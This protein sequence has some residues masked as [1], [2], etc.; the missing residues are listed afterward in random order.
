[1]KKGV[2]L[3]FFLSLQ[4]L[5]EYDCI[6]QEWL[7]AEL[8]NCAGRCC[9][10]LHDHG[11][12]DCTVCHCKS[13]AANVFLTHINPQ[14]IGYQLLAFFPSCFFYILV[15]SFTGSQRHVESV[16]KP[17][18]ITCN[19][20]VATLHALHITYSSTVEKNNPLC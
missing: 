7:S 9:Y 6:L 12:A 16:D 18:D 14:V 2:F 8:Q 5:C 17:S 4:K 13:S 10:T 20:S 1:M 3:V 15:Y 19:Q 11:G